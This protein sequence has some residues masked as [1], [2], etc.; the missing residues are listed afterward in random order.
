MSDSLKKYGSYMGTEVWFFTYLT[1]DWK[2]ALCP[3]SSRGRNSRRA[4]TDSCGWDPMPGVLAPSDKCHWNRWAR[5]SVC[6]NCKSLLKLMIDWFSPAE[7]WHSGCECQE[8]ELFIPKWTINFGSFM[9]ISAVKIPTA[10]LQEKKGWYT[11]VIWPHTTDHEE[12]K[13][14]LVPLNRAI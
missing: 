2:F 9:F 5:S 4:A 11:R 14:Q 3:V 8:E 1:Y 12:H 6:V 10:F 7:V 13:L